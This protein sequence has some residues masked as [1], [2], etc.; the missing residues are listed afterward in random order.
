MVSAH[1]ELHANLARERYGSHSWSEEEKKNDLRALAARS[2][3]E[4][5]L[6]DGIGHNY[7]SSEKEGVVDVCG[8]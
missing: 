6:C 2:V 5:V 3:G 1:A 7:G 4:V 8:R